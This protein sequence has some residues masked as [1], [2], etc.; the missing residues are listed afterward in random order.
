MISDIEEMSKEIDVFRTNLV[1][2]NGLTEY[3]RVTKDEISKNTEVA[4]K[5]LNKLNEYSQDLTKSKNK[6]INSL[7]SNFNEYSQDLKKFRD[8]ISDS[9]NSNLNENSQDLTKFR[10]EISDSVNAKFED[11][12][13]VFA[14][15]IHTSIK[16]LY[17]DTSAL[18]L[19]IK[20]YEKEIIEK[21]NEQMI[22]Q[23]ELSKKVDEMNNKTRT[24][25][26]IL[27]GLVSVMLILS[28]FS[29]FN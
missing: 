20:L 27:I 4:F 1:G 2:I 13:E 21:V 28:V 3:M 26:N 25:F 8:E 17:E 9:L 16:K 15:T 10:D 24:R 12:R 14:L 11:S 6:F 29:L 23:S 22:L 7:N 5:H 18:L 19:E